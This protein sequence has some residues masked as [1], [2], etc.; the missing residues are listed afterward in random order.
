VRERR[1]LWW[2]YAFKD[3]KLEICYEEKKEPISARSEQRRRVGN[4]ACI[5]CRVRQLAMDGP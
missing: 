2:S 1:Q 4:C 5:V 3:A